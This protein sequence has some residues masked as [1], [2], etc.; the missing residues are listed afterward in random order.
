MILSAVLIG[1]S[2]CEKG[3]PEQPDTPPSF[4]EATDA[5][6]GAAPTP[7]VIDQDVKNALAYRGIVD[8]YFDLVRLGKAD[9]AE[10]FWCDADNAGPVSQRLAAAMP[11]KFNNGMAL[12]SGDGDEHFVSIQILRADNT[13]VMDGRA[14][15]RSGAAADPDPCIASIAFQPPP[16]PLPAQ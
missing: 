12:R 5:A 2:A 14:I 13:N 11:Y 16:E 7:P 9:E 15:V 10:G 6:P 3:I 8:L 1:C 4:T